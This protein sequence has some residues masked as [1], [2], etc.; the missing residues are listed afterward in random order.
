MID[1]V[2]ANFCKDGL[3]QRLLYCY[4][5]LLSCELNLTHF[6][7]NQ[8]HQIKITIQERNEN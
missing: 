8:D 7:R 4:L 1:Q 6:Q 5:N 3:I 2:S